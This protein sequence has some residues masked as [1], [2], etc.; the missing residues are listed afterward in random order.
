MHHLN[1]DEKQK[2]KA[3]TVYSSSQEQFKK[4][5]FKDSIYGQ[6]STFLLNNI[7]NVKRDDI[8]E[9]YSHIINPENM[10]IAVVGD[11]DEFNVFG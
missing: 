2:G 8:V 6:N 1:S 3:F 7:N 11:V 9:F 5:A 10:S 4:L